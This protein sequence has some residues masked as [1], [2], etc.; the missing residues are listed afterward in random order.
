MTNLN[1]KPN[2]KKG[3][4]LKILDPSRKA[5]YLFALYANHPLYLKHKERLAGVLDILDGLKHHYKKIVGYEKRASKFVKEL[6]VLR[7]NGK[8]FNLNAL[9][10][11]TDHQP[12]VHE[13]VAYIGRVGMLSYFF[14][15]RWFG[16]VISEANLA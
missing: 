16:D 5:A 2:P 11:R 14:E 6:N 13:A 1:L 15:S 7:E 8:P 10:R 3:T 12:A 4:Y 9:L